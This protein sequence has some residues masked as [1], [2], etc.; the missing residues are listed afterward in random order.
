VRI[1]LSGC[2]GASLQGCR[3]QPAQLSAKEA[4]LGWMQQKAT[5]AAP[6]RVHYAGLLDSAGLE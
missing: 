4:W 1:Q 6:L 5:R 2:Q 3:P